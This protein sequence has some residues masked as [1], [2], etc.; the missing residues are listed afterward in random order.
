[1]ASETHQPAVTLRLQ[2]P[3]QETVARAGVSVRQLPSEIQKSAMPAGAIACDLFWELDSEPIDEG[4]DSRVIDCLSHTFCVLGSF[5]FISD[6]PDINECLLQR[7]KARL[8]PSRSPIIPIAKDRYRRL[9]LPRVRTGTLWLVETVRADVARNFFLIGGW[10]YA[11]CQ[12][13][14]LRDAGSAP[15]NLS[16]REIQNVIVRDSRQAMQH[17]LLASG[18]KAV[19]IPGHD[20]VW[21]QFVFLDVQTMHQFGEQLRASCSAYQLTCVIDI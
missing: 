11:R 12:V 17:T 18:S 7:I 16:D 15:L 9:H 10:H 8:W 5:T 2:A 13:G 14:Y 21:L 1:M 3:V 4:M 20:G 19:C 6:E